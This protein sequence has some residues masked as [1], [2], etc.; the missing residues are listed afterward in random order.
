MDM[1]IVGKGQT[2]WDYKQKGLSK[3]QASSLKARDVQ[4]GLWYKFQLKICTLNGWPCHTMQYGTGQDLNTSQLRGNH[5]IKQDTVALVK[6]QKLPLAWGKK[7]KKD[8]S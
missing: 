1:Q 2:N 8:A 5:G 7:K 4:K 6:F 3:H